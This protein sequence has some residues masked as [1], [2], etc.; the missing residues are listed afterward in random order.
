[1]VVRSTLVSSGKFLHGIWDDPLCHNL[2][3]RIR[4]GMNWCPSSFSDTKLKKK[5]IPIMHLP[6]DALNSSFPPPRAAVVAFSSSS[7]PSSPSPLPNW[8]DF[9]YGCS[10]GLSGWHFD[11]VLVASFHFPL[12]SLPEVI[13]P[14]LTAIAAASF[15][16]FIFSLLSH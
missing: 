15:I 4:C 12:L 5:D 8:M 6:S 14:W 9:Y 7:S 1:M 16:F 2:N 13:I 11:V 10:R 3:E